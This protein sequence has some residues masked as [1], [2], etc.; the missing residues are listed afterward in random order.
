MRPPSTK[1]SPYPSITPDQ[2]RT[3]L[4]RR[5]ADLDVCKRA[6]SASNFKEIREVGHKVKGNARVF[7]YPELEA[8]ARSLEE[9]ANLGDAERV[10]TAIQEFEAALKQAWTSA[11]ENPQD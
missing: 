11:K 6:A 9:A 5:D 4:S 7:G 2:R 1:S 10:A 3:Y 8:I